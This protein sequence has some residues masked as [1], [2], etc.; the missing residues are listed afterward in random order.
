MQAA[1]DEADKKS[2]TSS[3][4]SSAPAVPGTLASFAQKYAF[5]WHIF[6]EAVSTRLLPI[7]ATLHLARL[8]GDF[9]VIA[10]SPLLS[11]CLHCIL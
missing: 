4:A 2:L 9:L 8:Y 10:L 11:G 7:V 3:P 5:M 1:V 6:C